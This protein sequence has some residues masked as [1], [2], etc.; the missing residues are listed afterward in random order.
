M[1]LFVKSRSF[2]HATELVSQASLT[3]DEINRI[4]RRKRVGRPPKLQNGKQPSW[5]TVPLQGHSQ[6]T[7]CARS[8]MTLD[9]SPLV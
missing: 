2:S 9:F 6:K 7:G 5:G 8:W 1:K 4:A 3:P